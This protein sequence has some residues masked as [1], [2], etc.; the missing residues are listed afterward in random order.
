VIYRFYAKILKK[1]LVDKLKSCTFAPAKQGRES[2]RGEWFCGGS[3]R[4]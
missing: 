4:A 1:V 2:E 3:L